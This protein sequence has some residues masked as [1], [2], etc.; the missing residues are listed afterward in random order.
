M[1]KQHLIVDIVHVHAE[2]V[3]AIVLLCESAQKYRALTMLLQYQ[4]TL[5]MT[6]TTNALSRV[7]EIS[8]VLCVSGNP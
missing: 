1:H 7:S 4:K 8:Q 5:S 3:M 2:K 6:S